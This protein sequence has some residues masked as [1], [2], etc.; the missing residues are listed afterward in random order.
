MSVDVSPLAVCSYSLSRAGR[1][2]GNAVDSHSVDALFEPRAG[3]PPSWLVFR[4]FPQAQANCRLGNDCFLTVHH[5]LVIP[6]F[7][8]V[9]L[10]QIPT[11][12][13]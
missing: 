11:E 10:K 1:R 9:W 7:D 4:C 6:L 2:S 3:H 13:G 8:S 5:S 12:G